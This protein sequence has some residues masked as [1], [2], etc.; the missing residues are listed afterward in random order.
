VA[1]AEGKCTRSTRTG[2]RFGDGAEQE[3][4]Q[5]L[6]NRIGE[7][8]IRHEHRS[9]MIDELLGQDLRRSVLRPQRAGDEDHPSRQP[10]QATFLP[11]AR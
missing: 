4:Q 11:R 6:A 1:P 8:R 9:P 7:V 3:E 10:K 5:G 2:D